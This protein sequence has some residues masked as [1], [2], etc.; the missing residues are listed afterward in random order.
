MQE[1][2]A[3]NHAG[4]DTQSNGR[5]AAP[6]P[7]P[8]P[9]ITMRE[10]SFRQLSHGYMVQVGCQ[11]FAIETPSGLIAKLSE[12]ILNPAATEQKWNEGRLF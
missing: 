11:T 5:L 7:P 12:Y 1:Q 2:A 4:Y 10:V 9:P 6:T 8:M 3:V